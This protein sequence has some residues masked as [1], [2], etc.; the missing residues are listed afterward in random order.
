MLNVPL[1][2]FKFRYDSSVMC[3]KATSPEP[4]DTE[5]LGK[6]IGRNE[7]LNTRIWAEDDDG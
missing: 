2:R 4:D 5:A 6:R 7:H 3:F 1:L